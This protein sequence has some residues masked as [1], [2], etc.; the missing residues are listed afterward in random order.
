VANGSVTTLSKVGKAGRPV[1]SAIRIESALGAF[2]HAIDG[3][4]I[5]P[6]EKYE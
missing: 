3:W 5:I 1:W 6:R 4:I 2:H